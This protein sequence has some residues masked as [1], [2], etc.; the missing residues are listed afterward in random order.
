[1]EGA[2]ARGWKPGGGPRGTE[3]VPAAGDAVGDS[4]AARSVSRM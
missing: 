2:A 4:L 1:M 3:V